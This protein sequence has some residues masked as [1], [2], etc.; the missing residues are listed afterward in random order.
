V[1]VTEDVEA[2]LAA[3]FAVMRPFLDERGWR[4][5]LGTEARMLGH[6]G[7]A[8][9]ARAS[10]ASETT[11]KAGAAEA[12]D[13]QALAALAPGR[14]RR[15]GAGRPRAG[16]AQPGLGQALDEVLEPGMRGS[17][18]A[19][20]TWNTLTLR[21]IAGKMAARGYRCG[22]DALARMMRARGYSLRG[23]SRVLEG[24]Q[25]EDRDAQFQ[26]VS[27]M[28][29]LFAAAGEPAVS[30]DTKKKEPVGPYQ[31]PGSRT[32][33]RADSR[34]QVRDHDFPDPELGKITPYGIYDLAANTGFV[35]V[36]TSHD[37]GAF[38][39]SALR[40]WWQHQGK[41]AYP[42]AEYLLIACDAGGSNG[43]RC[44]L[45]K[46]GLEALA[47]ETGLTIMVVHLPPGTSKWN[48]IEHRLFCHITRTWSAAPLLTVEHALAGIEATTTAGGLKVTAVLDDGDYPDGIQVSDER[49][50]YLED[51]VIDRGAFHGEWNYAI[52][53][54]PR[55][56]PEPGPGPAPAGP[57]PAL[58]EA[59]AALAGIPAGLHEQAVLEWDAAR[60][61]QLTLGR[62]RQRRRARRRDPGYTRLS[63]QAV[64][65]AAACHIRLGMTWTLLGHLL[66]VHEST[67]SV[68][69]NWAIPVLA[70]HGITARPGTGRIRTTAQLLEHAAA[71]GIT[72]T[73][74]PPGPEEPPG[75]GQQEPRDTPENHN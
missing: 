23:M 50:R 21:G 73:I 72:L 10:G 60:E 62:G 6:G 25:H 2:G 33:Q 31:R 27:D 75:T 64:L 47:A 37:T 18:V 19:A 54:R 32:W 4:V 57:D 66:G 71:S 61:H 74:R 34:V 12:A 39:A 51:R 44:R 13:G 58:L 30:A 22:K 41:A 69:G 48:K 1:A 45:W 53:P 55:D 56:V 5:Y 14:S 59:L 11:V 29:A 24:T 46:S 42:G 8:A 28:I 52:L 38:A 20:L 9:V 49:M 7:I 63:H 40:L 68:P 36:G 65:T 70:A 15:P 16:D 35:S 43:Y 17:P 67:I 26:H 3:K